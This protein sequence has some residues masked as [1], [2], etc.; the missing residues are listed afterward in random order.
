MNPGCPTTDKRSK[1]MAAIGSKDT[2][3]E[4]MLRKACHAFGLRYRLHRSDLP[5]TPDF[6]FMSAKVAVFVDGDFW[7]GRKWF[8][9]R[10]APERNREYWVAKF[11]RNRERDRRVDAELRDMGWFPLR[12]WGSDVKSRILAC[13]RLVRMAVRSRER[14]RDA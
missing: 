4:I 2:E 3:P 1:I 12:F 8:E 5:G 6:A 11:E 14:R 9:E 7:H 13:A 10:K